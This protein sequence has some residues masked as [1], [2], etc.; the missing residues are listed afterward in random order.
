VT[1]GTT[2]IGT[3]AYAGV[4]LGGLEDGSGHPEDAGITTGDDGDL[5]TGQ[6]QVERLTAAIDLDGVARRQAGSG[7]RAGGLARHRGHSR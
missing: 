2:W 5:V 1:P 3:A 7:L 4:G 6:R